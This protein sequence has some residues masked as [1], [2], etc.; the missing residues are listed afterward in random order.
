MASAAGR[1]NRHEQGNA[2]SELHPG[3]DV[4][5]KDG[6]CVITQRLKSLEQ[7]ALGGDYR[8]SL[9]QE[10]VPLHGCKFDEQGQG[11]DT[12]RGAEWAK[13]AAKQPGATADRRLAKMERGKGDGK[14]RKHKEDGKEEIAKKKDAKK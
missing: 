14:K 5:R 8:V 7:I 3:F 6:E 11:D 4:A 10:L 9:K 2:N 13:N 12:E 1:W